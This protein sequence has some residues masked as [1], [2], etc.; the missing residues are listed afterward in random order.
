MN[1]KLKFVEDKI[2]WRETSPEAVHPKDYAIS[3]IS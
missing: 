3:A 1:R 2:V